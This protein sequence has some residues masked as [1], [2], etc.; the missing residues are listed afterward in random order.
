MDE[1]MMD[2]DTTEDTMMEMHYESTESDKSLESDDGSCESD[3]DGLPT[4][5]SASYEHLV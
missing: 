2:Q 3:S 1:D 5:P 4:S